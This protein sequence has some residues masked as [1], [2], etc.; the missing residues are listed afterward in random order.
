MCPVLESDFWKG[1]EI[2]LGFHWKML[3]TDSP[4]D[5][6]EASSSLWAITTPTF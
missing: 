2:L 5:Y 1:T 4:V 6:Y 3:P